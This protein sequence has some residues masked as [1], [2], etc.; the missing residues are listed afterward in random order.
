MNFRNIDP[1]NYL[2]SLEYLTGLG[3][4]IIRM[5]KNTKAPISFKSDKFIDYAISD[6]S[7]DFLDIWLMANC[8]FCVTPG[9]GIDS[10]SVAFRKPILYL[11]FL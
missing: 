4:Y 2:K 10:V 7:D 3:Y 8:S 6:D 5:G 11:N 9:T 1:N